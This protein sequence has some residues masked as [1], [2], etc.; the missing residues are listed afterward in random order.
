M[1]S[2]TLGPCSLYRFVWAGEPDQRITIFMKAKI[3]TREFVLR[4]R[5]IGTLA[6]LELVSFMLF[7]K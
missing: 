6:D 5:S 4:L 3:I 1:T 7:G 2:E